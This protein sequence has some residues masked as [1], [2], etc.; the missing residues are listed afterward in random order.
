MRKLQGH[1]KDI[2][3]N[4]NPIFSKKSHIF[5]YKIHSYQYNAFNLDH[6]TLYSNIPRNY[7]LDVGVCPEED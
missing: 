5:N 1:F 4:K 2:K 3:I 7:V 6:L